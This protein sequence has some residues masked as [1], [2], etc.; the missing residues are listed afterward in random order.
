MNKIV[1][2]VE[3]GLVSEVYCTNGAMQVDIIDKDTNVL[4]REEQV[5][6]ALK[7][8]ERENQAGEMK[9]VY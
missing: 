7:K 4:E 1:V 3:K 6:M 8:L 9:L 2:V 5:A